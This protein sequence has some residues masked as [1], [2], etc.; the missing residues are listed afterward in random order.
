MKK[1]K[2]FL[3]VCLLG[4]V[5][6]VFA[7]TTAFTYQGQLKD[8]ANPANGSHDFQFK[9]FD[10][11]A[12]GTGTQQGVTV[13]LLNVSVTAGVFSVQLDFGAG[14]FTGRRHRACLRQALRL[15]CR[16]CA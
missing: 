12:I 13:T 6:A 9:L 16:I 4:C 2:C 3:V 8:G 7:Q 11:Q 15:C 5:S 14:V 1:V 10:T